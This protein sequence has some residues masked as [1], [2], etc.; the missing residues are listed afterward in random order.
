[1]KVVVVDGDYRRVAINGKDM[2]FREILCIWGM[3]VIFPSIVAKAL[4]W[5]IG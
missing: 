5:L 1:M 3:I 2:M 4:V